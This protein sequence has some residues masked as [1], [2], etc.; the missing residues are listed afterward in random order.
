[1]GR[2]ETRNGREQMNSK[3]ILCWIAFDGIIP[4]ASRGDFDIRISSKWSTSL[5]FDKSCVEVGIVLIWCKHLS[6]GASTA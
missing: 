6:E 2:E 3:S 1:M 5:A 4:L